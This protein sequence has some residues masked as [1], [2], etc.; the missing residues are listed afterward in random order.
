MIVAFFVGCVANKAVSNMGSNERHP[1]TLQTLV[2]GQRLNFVI[3]QPDSIFGWQM[4][5]QEVR[6]SE[7]QDVPR[8]SSQEFQEGLVINTVNGRSIVVGSD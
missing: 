8:F 7:M 3:S 1:I 5:I 2:G 6:M 4:T